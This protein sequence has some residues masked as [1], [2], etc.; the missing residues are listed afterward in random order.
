MTLVC[1][2]GVLLGLL[3]GL[4]GKFAEWLEDDKMSW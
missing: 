1:I 4:F 2:P 3:S